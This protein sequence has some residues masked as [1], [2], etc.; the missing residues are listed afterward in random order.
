MKLTLH[1]LVK[2]LVKC[3]KHSH[4]KK[5]RSLTKLLQKLTTTMRRLQKSLMIS[6]MV[7]CKAKVVRIMFLSLHS[8]QHLNKRLLSSSVNANMGQKSLSTHT[9]WN[10]QLRKVSY[11]MLCNATP[12]LNATIN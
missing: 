12:P 11:L 7:I 4:Y 5:L 2:M 10:K 9:L 3:V 8:L 1:S 6:Y